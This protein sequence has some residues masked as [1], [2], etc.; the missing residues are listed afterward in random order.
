MKNSTLFKQGRSKGYRIQLLVD[1]NTLSN[2]EYKT[3]SMVGV[4]KLMTEVIKRLTIIS[5]LQ[6]N[7]NMLTFVN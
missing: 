3:D 5:Y 2:K 1:A 6:H 7:T 4:I